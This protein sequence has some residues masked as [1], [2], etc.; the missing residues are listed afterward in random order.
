[1]TNIDRVKVVASD[2]MREREAAR[3]AK[4]GATFSTHAARASR[5][6]ADSCSEFGFRDT[7]EA[8]A[9]LREAARD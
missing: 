6:L 4:D 5:I 2:Y 1:M 8:A 3:T 9:K 7:D